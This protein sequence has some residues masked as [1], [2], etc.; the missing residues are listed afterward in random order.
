MTDIIRNKP[1]THEREAKIRSLRESLAN[2]ALVGPA[3]RHTKLHQAITE[4]INQDRKIIEA[5]PDNERFEGDIREM[6]AR[7]SESFDLSDRNK[8]L[9]VNS[10]RR[11]LAELEEEEAEYQ[12]WL[13]VK[14]AQERDN[15]KVFFYMA[16]FVIF[17]AIVQSCQSTI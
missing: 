2:D 17:V 13:L 11:E 14:V 15:Y 3:E 7:H 12:E 10:Y 4:R 6:K 5:L 1:F 8:S 16:M 9:Q